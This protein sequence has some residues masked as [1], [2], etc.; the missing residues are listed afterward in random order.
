MFL[1]W[2][3]VE[4]STA[5]GDH[6][7][8]HGGSEGIFVATYHHLR[9]HTYIIWLVEAACPSFHQ[10]NRSYNL[11]RESR[12]GVYLSVMGSMHWE[13]GDCHQATNTG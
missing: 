3:H 10:I 11:S 8:K 2:D 6:A 7:L 1:S 9:Q 12:R 13:H 5:F 4:M